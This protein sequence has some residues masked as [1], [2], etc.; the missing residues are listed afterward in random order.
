MEEFENHGIILILKLTILHKYKFQYLQGPALLKFLH[1]RT[2]LK[3]VL[4]YV[5]FTWLAKLVYTMVPEKLLH[6]TR[7]WS[8]FCDN[9]TFVH[10]LRLKSILGYQFSIDNKTRHKF[11]KLIG[12][13]GGRKG[14]DKQNKFCIWKYIDRYR[15]VPMLI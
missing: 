3:L 2:T 8:H 6:G 13:E 15:S 10:L 11:W 12:R 4:K 9:F 14:D 1:L 5:I 7:V